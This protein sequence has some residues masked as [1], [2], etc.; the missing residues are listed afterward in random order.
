MI[1][2]YEELNDNDKRVLRTILNVSQI[3]RY[4]LED[5]NIVLMNT[6][7]LFKYIFLDEITKLKDAI[8][9]INNIVNRDINAQNVN[10]TIKQIILESHDKVTQ[11][12]DN[13]Y[14]YKE[15]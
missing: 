12:S 9:F 5:N 7:N 14:M 3:S 13:I 15:S 11:I 10:K 6:D 1:I 4:Y 2:E 8:V